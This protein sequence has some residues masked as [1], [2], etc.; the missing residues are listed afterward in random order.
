MVDIAN[1]GWERGHLVR[2]PEFI[3]FARGGAKV[4]DR[5]VKGLTP[6]TRIVASQDADHIPDRVFPVRKNPM[7]AL[8]D[9]DAFDQIPP[10]AGLKMIELIRQRVCR[11]D[12]ERGVAQQRRPEIEQLDKLDARFACSDVERLLVK[13]VPRELDQVIAFDGGHAQRIGDSQQR[14]L[15]D[16]LHTALLEQRIPARSNAGQLRNFFAPQA[17]DVTPT[18][19]DQLEIGRVRSRATAAQKRTKFDPPFHRVGFGLL[20]LRSQRRI[21]DVHANPVRHG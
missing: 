3:K 19:P 11:H 7:K 14:P 15:G 10:D 13:R 21:A 6:K 4:L 8:V 12:I 2:V 9:K 1:L 20:M 17:F 16:G 18:D 5:F